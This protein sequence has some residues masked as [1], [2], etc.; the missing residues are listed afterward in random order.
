MLCKEAPKTSTTDDDFA[1]AGKMLAQ[2]FNVVYYLLERIRLGSRTLTVAPEVEG[3]NAQLVTELA[4]DGEIRP[5][6]T[7]SRKASLQQV[8]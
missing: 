6:V 1:V 5:V 3:K 8:F 7:C 2:T 4:V